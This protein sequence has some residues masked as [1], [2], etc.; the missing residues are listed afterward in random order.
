MTQERSQGNKIPGPSGY[1]KTPLSDRY[2]RKLLKKH[3]RG[4][5]DE[6]IPQDLIEMKREQLIAASV[7][8]Q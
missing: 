5:T 6:D 3:F 4:M 2:V 7:V 1:F 8:S